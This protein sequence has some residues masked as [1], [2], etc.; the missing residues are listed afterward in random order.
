[1]TEPLHG[2]HTILVVEDDAAMRELVVESLTEEGYAV[3]SA[4]GGR[5]GVAQVRTHQVDLVVTDIRM[6]DMDGLDMVRELCT[7]PARPDVI[8]VTAFGSIETA[9]KAV[10][11][12]AS[13]YITKPF[14]IDQLLLAVER[15]LRERGIRHELARLREAVADKYRFDNIIGRSAAMQEVFELIRRVADSPVSVLITGESGTGKE[16]VARA[17]HFNSS[18]SS[19]PFIAVNCAAIP[20]NLLESELFG[21]KRGAF[22]DAT[23]DR[24]GLL[25]DANGGSL[26]LDE[27]GELPPP[28]QAK[29]LRV[30][31][32]REVKPLGSSRSVPIDVRIMSATN[33]DLQAM[34]PTGHF[35]S[36]LYYRLNV[37][38]I[39][40]PPLRDRPED[41]LPLATHLLAQA[42]RRANKQVERI[43]AQAA[44]LL[45]AYA[46]PGNVRELENVVERAV[47]LS[48]TPQIEVADLPQP[49]RERPA[50]DHLVS[51]ASSR[52]LT[53]A[54]LER[55]Y[56]LQVL[57]QEE[58]NKSRAANRLGLDRK[59]L[60]RKLEEYRKDDD[61]APSGRR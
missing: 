51:A 53:L 10:K 46:W 50:D 33:R 24:N 61:P 14:E 12:G 48:Q 2:R 19:G 13:D 16:L 44:K 39:A 23:T 57:T 35:R 56:I 41:I 4:G 36:D 59:T 1:M 34:L 7:L 54:E 52:N 32:E 49:L 20:P 45:L 38:Q 11:L 5:D 27:I 22:T 31:Q 21:Y 42:G 26:F 43:D 58:G 3:L 17:L 15:T 28:L 6:P 40:I 8:T 30:L 55:E 18:R 29:L 47:A 25:V 9:I 60:Y 37:V